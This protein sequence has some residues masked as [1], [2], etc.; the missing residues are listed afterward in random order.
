LRN[1]IKI[2]PRTL[3]GAGAVIMKDTEEREVYVPQRVTL[4]D[5]KS[6]EIEL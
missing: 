6:D 5:K 1:S 3:I 4:W 2:A